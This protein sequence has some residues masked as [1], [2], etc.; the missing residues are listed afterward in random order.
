MAGKRRNTRMSCILSGG[1]VR[2]GV[3]TGFPIMQAAFFKPGPLCRTAALTI[4]CAQRQGAAQP[5]DRGSPLTNSSRRW[6]IPD[7]A[8]PRKEPISDGVDLPSGAEANAFGGYVWYGRVGD[9]T[10]GSPRASAQALS[11]RPQG[12]GIGSKQAGCESVYFIFCS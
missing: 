7:H 12:C 2:R 9:F 11:G 8:E 1:Y 5:A 3:S 6:G 10:I 4:R